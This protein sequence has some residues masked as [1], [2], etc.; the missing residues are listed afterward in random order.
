VPR[1]SCP[2]TRLMENNPSTETRCH[3]IL[4]PLPED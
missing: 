2:K 4:K 1:V 3:C